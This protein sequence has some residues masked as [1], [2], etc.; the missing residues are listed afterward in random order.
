MTKQKGLSTLVTILL[1][2]AAMAVIAGGVFLYQKMTAVKVANPPAQ[3]VQAT[4]TPTTT[5]APA[6]LTAK[7][8]TPTKTIYLRGATVA[9]QTNNWATY[10]FNDGELTLKYPIGFFEPDKTPEAGYDDCN[11]DVSFRVCPDIT[12][13]TKDWTVKNYWINTVGT[14]LIINNTT[15]CSY[16]NTEMSSGHVVDYYLYAVFQNN[17]C[18]SI[19]LT[20]TSD[21]C[22]AY[23]PLKNGDTQ[24][25]KK[26]EACLFRNK[27]QLSTLNQVITTFNMPQQKACNNN[28]DCSN[29]ASCDTTKWL[30][31]ETHR[32]CMHD[33]AL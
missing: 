8:P 21:N 20:V 19:K 4:P 6:I 16:K 11:Y 18:Y 28:G 9:E 32:T 1:I 15:Y 2:I 30:N 17:R 29:G 3:I 10:N 22:T 24:Q 14:K 33:I 31:G 13:V 25:Q 7:Q 27:Q 5:S 23:L 26:Y 12:D